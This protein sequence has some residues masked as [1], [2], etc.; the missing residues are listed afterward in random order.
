MNDEDPVFQV[1]ADGIKAPSY[2]EVL[3]HFKSEAR[4]IF[5]DDIN[6]DEDTADGQTL[7]IFSLALHDVNSQAIALYNAFSPK[8]AKGV[9]LDNVCA[10]N[11]VVRHLATKSQVDLTLI[12][13]AGAEI[14]NGIALDSFNNR[15]LLP[16][17]VVIPVN[18]EITVT[19][20]AEK[21]GA[22]KAVSGA[23]TKIGT[24]T[25][26][27]QSVTNKADAIE[28]N[29]AETDSELRERQ[30]RSTAL[31]SVSIWDGIKGSIQNLEGVSRVA[32]VKNDT[33]TED[34][35]GI[36]GHTIALIVDGGNVDD[37]G[38]TI[39]IKK[40]EGV[41]TYGDIK[42]TYMDS[43]GY[44]NVVKF[45]RPKIVNIAVSLSIKPAPDYLSSVDDEIKERIVQYINGLA[46]GTSVNLVRV[47]SSATKPDTGVDTRFDVMDIKLAR[48]G[49]ALSAASVALLWNEAAKCSVD[50]IT[51]EVQS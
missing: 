43:Y 10:Q 9:A 47:L 21:A 25:L 39:Y 26:G 15:W 49:S 30:A 33:G 32:G 8:T 48:K 6:L 19:A 38:R 7:A 29:D 1:T 3:D 5:G 36:P 40:G 28:G 11:G 37:I 51:I 24:P 4:R 35:N 16:S 27:W 17:R 50:D 18:G 46:I 41:G 23:I 42:T 13:Q 14:T 44:P 34:D 12:G 2:E 20:T 45:S 22:I 31:P